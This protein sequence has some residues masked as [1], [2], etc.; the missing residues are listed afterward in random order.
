MAAAAKVVLEDVEDKDLMN[1]LLRRMKCAPKPEKRVVLIGLS[2]NLPFSRQCA[3]KKIAYE[4]KCVA[5]VFFVVLPLMPSYS[6]I[7]S[8][9]SRH[10]DACFGTHAMLACGIHVSCFSSSLTGCMDQ[11]ARCM[12]E[13]LNSRNGFAVCRSA[14]MRQGDTIADH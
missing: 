4:D 6:R 12:E 5:V 7:V 14:W 11:A 10:F 3:R 1:E 8:V 13:N 2:C 9:I